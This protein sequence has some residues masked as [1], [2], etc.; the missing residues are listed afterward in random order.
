MK[1][2]ACSVSRPLFSGGALLTPITKVSKM[3]YY[4]E[5]EFVYS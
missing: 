4:F 3:T 5:T 2:R 1:A